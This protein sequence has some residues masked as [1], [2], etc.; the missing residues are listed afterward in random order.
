MLD[1][2]ISNG[3][4][5]DGTGAPARRADVA[6]RGGR[7]VAVGEITEPA[8]RTIDA[9][10][11][12][13][14]PGIIDIHTHYDAQLC[15]D[16]YATPSSLHGT[17]TVI[18]GNCGFS[19]APVEETDIEYMTRL[20]A[21]VEGMPLESLEAAVP[22][23]WRSFGD[24]LD[25]FEGRLGINAGFFV[26]HTAVRRAVLGA[27][28]ER[29]ATA[30]ELERMRQLLRDGL[31]AGGLGFATGTSPTHNDAAGRPVPNRFASREEY[32]ELAR[33][34]GEHEGTTLEIVPPPG[35]FADDQ[36]ELMT[37]MSAAADRPINWNLLN[38]SRAIWDDCV[39]RLAASDHA[40]RH[41]G[42]ILA[43]TLPIANAMR[44]NFVSGFLFDVLPV[45]TQLFE[46]QPAERLQILASPE[47]RA[48]L[49]RA[50]ETSQGRA[51][52]YLTDWGG[53]TIGQTFSP[54]NTGLPG[55]TVGD[56]A[57]ERR[58]D[59]FD[60]LLDIIVADDLRTVIVTP[61]RGDDA[62]SWALR[63]QVIRDRRA[64]AG[65]SDCG[66]HVDMLDTFAMTTSLL[67]PCVRDRGMV[68]LE[69][70]VHMLTGAPAA[71]YGLVDRG[72]LRPGAWADVVVFDARTVGPG[73]IEMRHDMPAGAPRLYSIP[74]GVEHVFVAGSQVVRDGGQLTGELPG[75]VLRSGR[76]TRTVRVAD[77]PY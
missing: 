74:T 49:R 36:I 29:H 44:L 22:W 33:V 62:E 12:V 54:A 69:E 28:A 18:G 68:G 51:L 56:I 59:P 43:L 53:L 39:Q 57:A 52:Y 30:A 10:G 40:A 41:G 17:T 75:Q 9:D 67:G 64:I 37:A 48:L 15:W 27:D 5:V 46:M 42:R 1:L 26:G 77:V 47:A 60:T 34:A 31:Q 7:L 50:A 2:L 24:Y 16:P 63:K 38:V 70:A 58:Q 61:V 23:D 19:I 11:L 14:A 73:E 3:E 13:V 72:V 20:L 45:F 35:R 4:V 55:R 25:R 6:V 71:L 65:G 21:R 76:D 32:V 8:T 66:A